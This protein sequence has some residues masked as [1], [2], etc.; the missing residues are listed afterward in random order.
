ML[1]KRG[2]SYYGN[3]QSDIPE[4]IRRY[5]ELNG[6]SAI[7]FADA[8]CKCGHNTFRLS[9][10]DVEGAATRKCASCSAEQ[11][12]GDSAEYLEE[13]DLGEC[14]C[15]CGGEELEVTAGV[16]IYDGSDDVRWLYLGCRCP[17][18]HLTAVYADWK[19]EFHGYRELLAMV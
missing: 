9:V 12:I 5:S 17:K 16:S 2:N 14:A 3:G 10:D 7:H 13:A 4:E 8:R 6:Y 18:C 11:A 15:P 1:T 19:N